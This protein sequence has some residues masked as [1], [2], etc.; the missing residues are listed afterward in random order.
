MELTMDKML[1]I[2]F[3]SKLTG[4]KNTAVNEIYAISAMFLCQ[5]NHSGYGKL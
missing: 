3:F 1:I 5:K 2:D 4:R